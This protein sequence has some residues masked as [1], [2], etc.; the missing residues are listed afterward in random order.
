MTTQAD[1]IRSRRQA[2]AAPGSRLDKIVRVLAV[3]LPAMIG[4]VVAMML[5]TPL[6]PRSEISFLL[7]RNKVAIAEDRL[8]MDNAM[9]RGEDSSGRP[10]SLSAGEAVQSSA[11]VPVVELHEL[12]ARIVLPEGPAVLSSPT[13]TYNIDSEQ[14]T[15]PGIVQFNAADGYQLSAR[16]VVIDL[17]TRVLLGNG[18]VEGEIPAGTFSADDFRADLAGRNLS[19]IGNARLRIVPSR[20]RMPQGM[21]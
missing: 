10:F 5:I 6:S 20:L 8:R 16:N 11:S 18:R 12:T 2:F 7:D 14:V 1:K 15:V 21:E 19:L 13:G 17:P 3:G 9:Y 4:V